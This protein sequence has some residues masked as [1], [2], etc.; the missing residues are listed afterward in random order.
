L[1]RLQKLPFDATPSLPSHDD[2]EVA[3]LMKTVARMPRSNVDELARSMLRAALARERSGEM[4]C[5]TCL[6]EDMLFTVRLRGCLLPPED[7]T[8]ASR[9]PRDE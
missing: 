5:L 6:A 2:A 8:E 4:T 9:C 1:S 7:A 3:G